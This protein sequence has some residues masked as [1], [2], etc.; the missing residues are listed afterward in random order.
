[1]DQMDWHAAKA[2]LD[3]QME[4]GVDEAILDAPV[5]RFAAEAELRAQHAERAQSKG[6]AQAQPVPK[7][8]EVDPVAEA[9]ALAAGAKDLEGLR[10]ALAGFEHCQL[11]RGARNLVFAD[12]TR[13][14]R[15]MLV[16]EAPGREEDMQG[17]PFVG[18]AGQLLDRML[19][20]VG[21]SRSESVYIT[22]VLPWRPPQNRDPKPEEIAMLIPFLQ[23]HIALVDPDVLVIMGNT[24][25]QALLGRRGI[26]RL[27]GQW[28]QAAGRPALPMLHPAYLLRTPLAKREAWAD[29]L[30]LKA[31]LRTL[32]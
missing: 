12:G 1:M 22:N 9:Q 6:L 26:T 27:R 2:L 14:A 5:D 19:A 10:A 17:K 18:Q 13:D 31:K 8:E 24:S 20:A 23:R 29:W 11:K 32:A 25:A 3:W 15:V 7:V 28:Q 30:E 4:M 16:G 21:L